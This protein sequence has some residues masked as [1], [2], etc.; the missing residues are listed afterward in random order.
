LLSHGADPNAREG[1]LGQTALMW[2]AAENHSA[3]VETLLGG[4]A[5]PNVAGKIYP[6][7]DLKPLDAGTPKAP[8]SRG[9][10]TA[11][12]YAARQGAV[13]TVRVLGE[14]GVDLNQTDPDGVTAL[15]YA[16]L[17][18]HTDTAALL[19]NMGANPNVADTFGRTVLY[20]AIDLN[21][22]EALAPRPAPKTNDTTRPLELAK[23]ALAK[24]AYVNSPITGHLPPRSTQGNNDSTPEG[25]TPLWRAA[26]TSDTEAMKLLLD[27]GADP[28]IASR[29]GITPVMVAA[30][31]AW[32]VDRARITTEEKS[33]AALKLLM[34]TGVDVNQR[35]NKGETA[36]H[37]AADRKA[38]EV[39]KFLAENGA[40]LD[41]KD[42]SNRTAL[43]IA[44][45][46][47]PVGGRNPFEYRDPTTKESTAALLRDL[48]TAKN[49]KIEPYVKPAETA[50]AP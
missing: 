16:T 34:A 18:G 47:P 37:G 2:A 31:Q 24:G 14:K 20:S 10:M 4:G 30:G 8:E 36:L 45:G 6:D 42:K 11:L 41:L 29:D 48:M 39:V 43:D 32:E 35:N 1:W 22:W 15:L 27:A 26:K 9:G 3:V 40:S 17:N 23:L 19:L 44:M 33:V 12:H 49:V 5:N 13:D 21:S 28:A 7:A 25:A 50:K 46:V 38:D